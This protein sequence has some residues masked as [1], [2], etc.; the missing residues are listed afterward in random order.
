[1]GKHTPG[2]WHVRTDKAE[3][4]TPYIQVYQN[5]PDGFHITIC[6]MGISDGE[7]WGGYIGEEEDASLI[8]AAPALLEA[9]ETAV[10]MCRFE[11]NKDIYCAACGMLLSA[12]AK[13]KS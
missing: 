10:S 7:V 1:M 13:A 4:G 3:D 11:C 8:A 6:T 9:C 5:H 12:I 2:P